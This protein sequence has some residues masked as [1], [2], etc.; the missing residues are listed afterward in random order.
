MDK[1]REFWCLARRKEKV[2]R[3]SNANNAS[4]RPSDANNRPTEELENWVRVI[5]VALIHLLVLGT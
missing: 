5:P 4:D 1:V 3:K 2:Y